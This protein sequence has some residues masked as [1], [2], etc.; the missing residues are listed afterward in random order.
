[1]T[2]VTPNLDDCED[3]TIGTNAVWSV[4]SAKPGFGVEQLRDDDVQTFWQSDGQQPHFVNIQ[5]NRRVSL[6]HI[7]FYVDVDIDES[8]T[9]S[10][11]AIKCGTN[12]HDL[13]V[14]QLIIF[15]K[16]KIN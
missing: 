3:Q 13:E 5:F 9:P 12:F 1:M 11:V 4:S 15:C 8:Y 2:T 10:K 14:C 6:T 7:A 16:K